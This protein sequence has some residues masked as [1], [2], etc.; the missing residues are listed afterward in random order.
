MKL[1]LT[2]KIIS[3]DL[4]I[5]DMQRSLEFYSDLLGLIILER[6]DNYTL[7]SAGNSTP[8]LLKLVEDVNA[9]PRSKGTTGLFHIALR[10]PGRKELA[11]VFL[12]L[13]KNKIKFQGFSDHLVSES[14]YL[15]DPDGNGIELYSDK[16]KDIWDWKFG[17]V[18]MDTL[19]LDLSIITNELDD[20]EIW[21]GIHPDVDI[22]HIHF[23]VSN[24]NESERFYNEILG[25][26]ITNKNYPGAIFFSAGGYHHHIGVNIWSSNNG[27]SPD[28]NSTG[29][30]NCTIRIPDK[31]FLSSIEARAKEYNIITNLQENILQLQDPDNNKII[32]TV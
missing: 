26:D 15:S 27:A 17:Q 9:L 32:L 25:F 10:F 7:L 3:V 8:Y 5:I 13:F 24:L 21:N 23:N 11:R 1:P 6:G 18:L 29:L 4:K 19:P 28:N 2:T 16:P 14:I 20:P 12:R 31:S 30:M 22:G